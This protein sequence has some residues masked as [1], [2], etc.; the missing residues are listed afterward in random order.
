MYNRQFKNI[1]EGEDFAEMANLVR[2][3]AIVRRA[4]ARE[5]DE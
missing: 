2:E 1:Q 4:T 3:R 5:D